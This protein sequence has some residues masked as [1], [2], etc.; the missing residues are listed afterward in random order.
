MNNELRAKIKKA[1]TILSRHGYYMMIDVN[2]KNKIYIATKN[3][4]FV[5]LSLSET[6]NPN[7]GLIG[8][9][10]LSGLKAYTNTMCGVIT[11]NMKYEQADEVCKAWQKIIKAQKQLNELEISGTREE[12]VECV[13]DIRDKKRKPIY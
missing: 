6:L 2:N 9:K 1:D 3:T 8:W 5:H 4:G 10:F 7:T 13:R 11:F 12:L